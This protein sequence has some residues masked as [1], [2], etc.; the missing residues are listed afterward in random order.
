MNDGSNDYRPD[1]GEVL[2]I[3]HVSTGPEICMKDVKGA[4]SHTPDGK[5]YI[6]CLFGDKCH[7]NTL[8]T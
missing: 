7:P 3:P 1:R 4:E 8:P 5:V 2:P 6:T